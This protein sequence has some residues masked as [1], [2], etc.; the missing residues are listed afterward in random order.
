MSVNAA[1]LDKVADNYL[2]KFLR[3]TDETRLNFYKNFPDKYINGCKITENQ[4]IFL[5]R[6]ISSNTTSL[7]RSRYEQMLRLIPSSK[8]AYKLME[9]MQ[10]YYYDEFLK[11]PT[12]EREFYF[13]ENFCG[14]NVKGRIEHHDSFYVDFA[15]HR[16]YKLLFVPGKFYNDECSICGSE[17]D[18]MTLVHKL[19]CGHAFHFQCLDMW[20]QNKTSCPHCRTVVV[21]RLKKTKN[22]HIDDQ[23]NE[24]VISI[25]TETSYK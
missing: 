11:N 12:V 21:K 10:D 15:T 1:S 8:I 6:I 24:F 16:R 18:E 2:L 4:V 14:T 7:P 19:T 23:S 5:S 25:Q 20:L 22:I 9:K 3:E 13:D 17:F